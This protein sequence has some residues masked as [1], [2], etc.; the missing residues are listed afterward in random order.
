VS[1]FGF[2]YGRGEA[3]V[4]G[5]DTLGAFPIDVTRMVALNI[6]V[7][8]S[9]RIGFIT[10]VGYAQMGTG[11]TVV[12]EDLAFTT[13][14]F[15]NYVRVPGMLQLELPLE[16]DVISVRGF[17]R[18]GLALDARVGFR[19]EADFFSDEGFSDVALARLWAVGGEIGFGRDPLWWLGMGYYN[20]RHVLSDVDELDFRLSGG[21]V[22]FS[23]RYGRHAR[24][25]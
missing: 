21:R 22:L 23:V 25:E 2:E 8:L 3:G 17:G 4:L 15:V 9:R 5:E 12:D 11:L 18:A 6:G 24:R 10:G 13:Q 14:L 1:W 19:D 16:T 20:E 7:P